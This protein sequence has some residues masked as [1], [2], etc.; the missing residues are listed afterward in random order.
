M[1]G[2]WDI[3]HP[4]HPELLFQGLENEIG[5]N[6]EDEF[7]RT[8]RTQAVKND[9]VIHTDKD[10]DLPGTWEYPRLPQAPEN[11]EALGDPDGL[12][13]VDVTCTL[14]FVEDVTKR[15]NLWGRAPQD[16]DHNTC[17]LIGGVGCQNGISRGR[18]E[19]GPFQQGKDTKETLDSTTDFTRQDYVNIP[20]VEGIFAP[21]TGKNVVQGATQYECF[22]HWDGDAREQPRETRQL[23]GLA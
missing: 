16:P 9:G 1:F 3:L 12:L 15:M 6:A 7:R 10:A 20:Q 2:G 19:G 5:D 4:R 17:R 22:R 8:A 18:I 13:N 23:A 11:R 21:G 14:G